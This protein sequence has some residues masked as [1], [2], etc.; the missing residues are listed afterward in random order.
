V[1]F[2]LTADREIGKVV[3]MCMF[4]RPV[5]HV[6]KTRIFARPLVDGTQAL[7]YSMNVAIAEDLAMIL[8]LPVPPKPP[9][10]AVRF[11]DLSAYPRFFA[12]LESAFPAP[13]SR[14]RGPLATQTFALESA[15]LEVHRVGEF[16]ASFVPTRDDFGRLDERFQLDASLWDQLPQYGGSGFAV[17]KLAPQR[18][19][20][21]RVR[22][23]SVHP[24]AFVFPRKDPQKIFFPTVHIHDGQVHDEAE[25]DH[26]LYCQPDEVTAATFGWRRSEEDV[27]RYVK[28]E[29]T[30]GLVDGSVL[31]YKREIF[32]KHANVDITLEPPKI[33]PSM[34]Q[35][36]GPHHRLQLSMVAAYYER[37]TSRAQ[38]WHRHARND[39]ALLSE[40]FTAALTALTEREAGA[41]KLAAYDESLTLHHISTIGGGQREAQ[42]VL[43]GPASVAPFTEGYEPPTGP[44]R[45][46]FPVRD[47]P[48]LETQQVIL[49]FAELPKHERIDQIRRALDAVLAEVELPDA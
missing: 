15:K 5:R 7:V 34:L 26:Q 17:F 40:R 9:E 48:R 18:G 23:Q 20:F 33:D 3:G 49:A 45:V 11:V 38:V 13:L 42:S 2:V 19:W 25:F 39:M 22:K 44:G 32:G 24:M 46:Q 10:D 28:A 21:R 35:R 4:S 36:R 12:D 30:G 47:E 16:E 31:A 29:R 14:G 1:G 8:P 27:G 6:A 43:T 41:W 37:P